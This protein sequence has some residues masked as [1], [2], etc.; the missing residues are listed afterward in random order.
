MIAGFLGWALDAYDYFVV[1]LALTAIGHSFHHPV[2]DIALTLTLTLAFRPVGAVIFG[3]AADRWGRKWPLVADIL[4]YSV[5]EVFS[6]LAPSFTWFLILRAL[7][8]IGMGGEWGVGAS[9]VMESSPRKHRGILSGL[10]QEGYPFGYLVAALVYWLVFNRFGWRPMFFI[11]GGAAILVLF[12]R[13]NVKEPEAWKQAHTTDWRE[14]GRQIRKHWKLF[15]YMIILMTMFNFAS[16]GT[17]DMYPTF[18]KLTHHFNTGAVS[19]ITIISMIGAIGG[20][21]VFG[22]YS[23]RR[24]R[25]KSM[26]VGLIAAA[27]LIPLWIYAPGEAGLAL[28]AFLIQFMVQGAWGVIPVHLNELS[29]GALRGFFPGFAY[30]LGVLCASSIAYVEAVL[31][32]NLGYGAAMA[33]LAAAILIVGAI[34]TAVGPEQHGKA[35]VSTEE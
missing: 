22:Y 7:Y 3:Y 27:I 31:S 33:I 18:L 17:Q 20:G 19:L 15:V 8:G 30:Q 2:K 25:R 13:A 23:D 6:G 28:G 21:L 9:L 4:Y 24:G 34:V 16:H 10:L 1:V 11:G 32:G 35:F 29:P 5:I 14:Y 26:V 12:I